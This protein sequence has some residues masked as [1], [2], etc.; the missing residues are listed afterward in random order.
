MLVNF[1]AALAARR[2][3]QADLAAE[4]EIVPSALSEIINGRRPL[5]AELAERVAHILNAD[6]EWLFS[7]VTH[8]PAPKPIREPEPTPASAFAV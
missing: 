6:A 8:I 1:K 3:R 2:M 7:P 4:L 5:T